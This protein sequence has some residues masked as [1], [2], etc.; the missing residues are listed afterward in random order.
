VSGL[1]AEDTF[2]TILA[3][4]L[5]LQFRTQPIEDSFQIASAK[6]FQIYEYRL[7]ALTQG[8]WQYLQPDRRP[9]SIPVRGR[10]NLDTSFGDIVLF[11]CS[12]PAEQ[13]PILE[14][15]AAQSHLKRAEP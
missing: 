10:T 5:G 2:E 14:C 1:V 7:F 13:G 15:A 4:V 12:I 6:Y 3:A 8:A 9:K 11:Q